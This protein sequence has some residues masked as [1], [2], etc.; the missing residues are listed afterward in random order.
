[1]KEY[2]DAREE[3]G[4]FALRCLQP[5][6]HERILE[7]G[8][9][10]GFFTQFIANALTSGTL[11]ATDPSAEQLEDITH[12]KRSNIQILAASADVLPIGV[13][14][15]QKESFDAIW[16][17]GSFHHVPNKSRAFSQFFSLLKKGGRLV[18]LDVFSGSNLAKHFDLEVA[19]Y[20]VTGHE[21]AF[22]SEAFADSLCFLSGFT[23]PAFYQETIL[24]KFPTKRDLGVFIYNLH[25][26]TA[27][28]PEECYEGA[29][30]VLGIEEKTG[31]YCLRWPLT[32]LVTYKP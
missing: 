13:G 22:L 3:E 16:S 25:A 30:A 29:K 18:I 20:C 4:A 14:S 19:K 27:R 32:A 9:G 28:T 1:M 12:L 23:K 31:Q 5:K 7:V 11:I 15:L 21:V 17:G 8:A 2:P 26:M 6:S 24:W 10:G